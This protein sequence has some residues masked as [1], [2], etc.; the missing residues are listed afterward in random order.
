MKTSIVTSVET[1]AFRAACEHRQ[2]L[3]VEVGGLDWN[4][5]FPGWLQRYESYYR[6]AFANQSAALLICERGEGFV[7]SCIASIQDEFRRAVSGKGIGYVN[8]MYVKPAFRKQ[9]VGTALVAAAKEWLH[10][11]GCSIVRLHPSCGANAFY[12]RL[13]FVPIEELE[14]HAS[15]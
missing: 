3:S 4:E 15:S 14:Y 2:A 7:A 5:R 11:R 1:A 6:T 12:R 13:G 9:H 8:G 10:E